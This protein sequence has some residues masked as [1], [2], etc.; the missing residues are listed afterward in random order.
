MTSELIHELSN[1][2]RIEAII[3]F[4]QDAEGDLWRA[5]ESTGAEVIGEM[6]ILDGGLIS[7][8]PESIAEISRFSF[9]RHMEANLLIE[10]FFLPKMCGTIC[11]VELSWGLSRSQRYHLLR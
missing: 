8:T 5:I 10:H 4:D 7:A 3:Q 11:C 1:P 9:V 2:D 6:E